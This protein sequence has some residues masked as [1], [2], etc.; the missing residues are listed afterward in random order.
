LLTQELLNRAYFAHQQQLK[1][2]GDKDRRKL[3]KGPIACEK[4]KF[5]RIAAK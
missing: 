3:M 5:D 2:G 4:M 1:T